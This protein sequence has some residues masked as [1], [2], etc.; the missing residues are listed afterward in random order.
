VEGVKLDPLV[1]AEDSSKPLLSKLLAVPSLRKRYLDHVRVLA[2]RWLDWKTLGP[3]AGRYHSLIAADV[4][5]D[6]RKLDS[7]EAFE[8]GLTSNASG[9]GEFRPGGGGRRISLKAFADQRRA[10]LISRLDELK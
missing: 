3:I 9:V 2:D 7:T 5:A 6:T 1:A 10:Y 8:D 4:G